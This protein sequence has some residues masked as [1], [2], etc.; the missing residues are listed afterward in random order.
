MLKSLTICCPKLDYVAHEIGDNICLESI[1]LLGC[2]NIKYLPQGLDRL[3]CLQNIRHHN[4]SN[5]VCFAESGSS[6]Y[7]LKSLSLFEYDK[8]EV[9]PN[10]YSLQELTIVSC[11]M[12][13]SIGEAGLPP[14]LA[15]LVKYDPNFSKL[16][17]EWGLHRFTSLK[18]LRIDGGDFIDVESF[19]QVKI[20]MNMKLPPSLT[21]LEIRNFKIIRKLS[22]KGFQNLTSLQFLNICICPKLKSLSKKEM[23]PSLSKLFICSCPG[24]K[25]RYRRDKG[26]LWSNIAHIPCVFIDDEFQ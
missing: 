26:K 15:S 14:N 8:L 11:P 7:N 18:K 2:T 16:V 25:K 19:P 4:C 3:S 22:S 24:L 23:L 17:M 5:L 21:H 6:A 1:E 10:L 9:L 13:K 12:M 20:G